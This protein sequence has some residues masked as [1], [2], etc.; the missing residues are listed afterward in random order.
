VR[1]QKDR[2]LSAGAVVLAFLAGQHH[3]LHMLPWLMES[4]VRRRARCKAGH[5]VDAWIEALRL[6]PGGRVLEIGAGP[7]YVSLALAAR[8]GAGGLVYAVDKSAEA[9][10]F[11]ERLRR[12]RGL[13]QI[14]PILGD[15]ATLHHA[16]DPAG[17]LRNL[18]RLLPPEAR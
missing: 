18:A 11:L 2:I 7:G 8:V 6:A 14:Q 17:I 12:E 5:P 3:T 13:S 15:A 4:A 1:M 9:L 16:A 10:A